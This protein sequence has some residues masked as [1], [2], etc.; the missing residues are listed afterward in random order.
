MNT[1]PIT[2]L[3]YSHFNFFFEEHKIFNLVI[4]LKLIVI[5]LMLILFN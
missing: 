3:K 5:K 2:L 4:T 1:V